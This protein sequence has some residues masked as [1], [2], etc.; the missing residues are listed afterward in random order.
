MNERHPGSVGGIRYP[1]R[2]DGIVL[3]PDAKQGM[4]PMQAV[5]WQSVTEVEDTSIRGSE[6]VNGCLRGRRWKRV[7]N[8]CRIRRVAGSAEVNSGKKVMPFLVSRV[9]QSIES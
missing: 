8:V 6:P 4:Q 3:S 1:R 5:V 9:M 2:Q 7:P